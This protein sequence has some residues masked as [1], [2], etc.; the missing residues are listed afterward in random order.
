MV[1]FFCCS[2]IAAR[3]RRLIGI[4]TVDEDGIEHRVSFGSLS[5][6]TN[7]GTRFRHPYRDKSE[8]PTWIFVLYLHEA[9]HLHLKA[10]RLRGR[11]ANCAA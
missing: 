10:G 1:R 8:D 6:R 4:G 9:R 2:R 11:R 5:D 7:G 3:A